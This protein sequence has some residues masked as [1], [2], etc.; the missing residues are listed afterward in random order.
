[1][2]GGFRFSIRNTGRQASNSLQQEAKE[3]TQSINIQELEDKEFDTVALTIAW[4]EFAIGLP[5]EETAMSRQMDYMEPSLL[6]DG[7]TFLVIADNPSV[8]NELNKIKPRVEAF[9]QQRL[10]NHNVRMTT[11]LREVTDKRVSYTRREI[12]NMML[13]QSEALRKLKEEFELE[14]T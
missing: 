1:M 10:Q 14:L 7:T 2:G 4:R 9:L 8:M 13:E 11:R 6:E 3:P 5:R 12:L